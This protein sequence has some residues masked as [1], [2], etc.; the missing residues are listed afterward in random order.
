M[1]TPRYLAFCVSCSFGFD[2]EV[3]VEEEF[4][5]IR[6]EHSRGCSVMG[7]PRCAPQD[8]KFRLTEHSPMAEEQA[9]AWER[10]TE[11]ATAEEMYVAML[12]AQDQWRRDEDYLLAQKPWL[13][14]TILKIRNTL[15]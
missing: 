8:V 10:L 6:A 4:P 7:H 3:F 15:K 11:E 1:S 5:Y 12:I 14:R 9:Q 13:V 2:G